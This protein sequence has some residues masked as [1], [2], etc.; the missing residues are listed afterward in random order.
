[1]PKNINGSILQVSTTNGDCCK[2]G[3]RNPAIWVLPTT[4][5]LMFT[6]GSRNVESGDFNNFD[7]NIT[8]DRELIP[9]NEYF[10][11]FTRDGNKVKIEII[12]LNTKET[13]FN[14]EKILFI[15]ISKKIL[16]FRQILIK[17]I[18]KAFFFIC[19]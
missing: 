7:S 16:L 9:D 11:S 1:M 10:I 13:F 15:L 14:L 5:R 19:V 4:T 12:D 8:V 17:L 18:F 2:L 6:T 3:D